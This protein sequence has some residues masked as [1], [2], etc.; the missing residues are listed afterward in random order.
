MKLVD[1]S[2]ICSLGFSLQ[3]LINFSHEWRQCYLFPSG[4]VGKRPCIFLRLGITNRDTASFRFLTCNGVSCHRTVYIDKKAAIVDSDPKRGI[5]IWLLTCL[6]AV[7][8]QPWSWS[9]HRWPI[10][11]ISLH[12]PSIPH[13]GLCNHSESIS[14][15]SISGNSSGCTSYIKSTDTH[16]LLSGGVG[17]PYTD[18]SYMYS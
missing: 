2:R 18:I 4:P 1:R 17:K 7:H 13:H 10:H 12:R 3:F 9:A 11:C 14:R 5:W 16:R 8:T 15:G 6:I